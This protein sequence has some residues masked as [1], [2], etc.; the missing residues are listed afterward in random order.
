MITT[1]ISDI[2]REI[3]ATFKRADNLRPVM[4]KIAGDMLNSI[5]EAFNE[6][7]D[8]VTNESWDDLQDSTKANR[9]QGPNRTFNGV[10]QILRDTGRLANSMSSDYGNDY[11]QAGTNVVYAPTHQFGARKGAYGT[12]SRGGPIPWGDVPARPF[13]GFSDE[14]VDSIEDDL[15][16]YLSGR[17]V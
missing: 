13:L 14:L 4:R 8:P 12:N 7:R 9:R 6:Q 10:F 2:Q 15:F 5:D 11:A 16:N 3:D 17:R 1:N